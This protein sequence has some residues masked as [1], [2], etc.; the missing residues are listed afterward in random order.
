MKI[1]FYFILTAPFIFMIFKFVLNFLSLL[2]KAAWLERQVYFHNL[3][4]HNLQLRTKYLEQ[5]GV[6]Q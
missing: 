4:R 6:I 1:A 2:G 3:W 5:N